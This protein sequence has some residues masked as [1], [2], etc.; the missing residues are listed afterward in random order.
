MLRW[1]AIGL[2]LA[3]CETL[4]QTAP[5]RPEARPSPHSAEQLNA[6][7]D[8]QRAVV[9]GRLSAARDNAVVLGQMPAIKPS[10]DRIA[11]GDDLATVG[12][13]LG[14]VGQACGTCHAINGVQGDPGAGPPPANGD[15]L[16]EQMHRNA[17]G[18]TRMWQG[19]SG[20]GDRA[21]TEGAEIIAETPLDIAS[22]MHEK[23]NAEAFELAEQ[24]R[25]QAERAG[26]MHDLESRAKLYG[27]MMQTCASCHRIMRPA[28]VIDTQR[29][30]VARSR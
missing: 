7:A 16:V 23:P 15:T 17:W 19:I 11:G 14:D 25:G 9:E 26:S 13:E 4:P 29:E 3:S 6:A 30:S 24:L 20:P 5:D 8:L 18:A 2:V 28:P 22:A 12:G 21:W 10:A 1:L 27:E